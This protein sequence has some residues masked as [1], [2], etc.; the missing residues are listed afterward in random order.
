MAEW[1]AYP[2]DISFDNKKIKGWDEWTWMMF[3]TYFQETS[4]SR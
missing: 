4:G 3:S 1:M 2:R